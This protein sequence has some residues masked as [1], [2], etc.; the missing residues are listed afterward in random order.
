VLE[1]ART[2]DDVQIVLLPR[3][4][5]Q[6]DRYAA[7]RDVVVPGQAVDGC[8][9][10]AAADVTIGAGGTMN[11]ESALLGTPTYTVFGGRM[12]A[13]DEELIRRGRLHDLRDAD[14]QPAFEKKTLKTGGRAELRR[15]R[16]VETVKHALT[17]AAA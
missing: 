9:L 3:L 15:D 4:S 13:A 8:S 12:A 1:A 17:R 16:I 11:R 5:D 14:A 7:L 6:A 2:R 10:L